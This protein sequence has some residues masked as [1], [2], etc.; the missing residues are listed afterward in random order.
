MYCNDPASSSRKKQKIS[1]F[2][3]E[4]KQYFCFYPDIKIKDDPYFDD[5]AESKIRRGEKICDISHHQP[6]VN[7]DAFIADTALII[8]RAGYRG[9]GTTGLDGIV[10][11]DSCFVKHADAMKARGVRFGVYFYSIAN[12]VSKAKEEAQAFYKYAKGYSPLFWAIDAEKPHITTDAIGAFADELRKLGCG[13]IGAYVANE[14]YDDPYHFD[15]VLNKFNFLWIPDYKNATVRKCDLWQYTST[16]SVDGIS[17]NVD[18]NKITG[19]GHDLDWFVK[20]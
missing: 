10:K 6:T 4:S 12:T 17:G 16:G 18:L 8:L 13:K 1:E 14:K 15:K 19:E 2:K 7:Y 9:T 20:E 11:I 3:S 5:G